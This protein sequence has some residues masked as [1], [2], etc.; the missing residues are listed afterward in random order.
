MAGIDD[1]AG[2]RWLGSELAEEHVFGDLSDATE[3]SPK[4]NVSWI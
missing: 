1:V 3:V 2:G 4:V